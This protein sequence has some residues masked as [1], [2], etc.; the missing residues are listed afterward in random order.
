M[1]VAIIGASGRMGQTLVEVLKETNQTL[2]AAVVSKNSPQ[3]GQPI[4]NICYQ[5][6]AEVT[7]PVDVI[8]DF[9][10]PQALAENLQFA[11]RSQTPIVVCTTGLNDQQRELLTNAANEIAVLY[12]R[13]TSVG[14]ALLEQLVALSAAAMADADLE[15]FEAHHK[16]KKDAPSG[17]ALALGEAAA[18]GR[19]QEFAAFDAEIRGGGERQPQSIGFSVMRAADIIGEHQVLLAQPG[20]RIELA[21]RVSDRKVFARGALTAAQWLLEQQAGLYTMQDTLNLKQTLARLLDG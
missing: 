6:L 9:S 20:E 1:K 19:Q 7:E 11:R 3:Q 18:K 5:A 14:I 16:F 15:I 13:N 4:A 12:A 21:H 10:L 2:A 8:I 17:T